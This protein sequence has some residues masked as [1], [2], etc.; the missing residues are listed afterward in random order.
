MRTRTG[1]TGTGTHTSTGT[2]ASRRR[3]TA[4][5]SSTRHRHRGAYRDGARRQNGIEAARLRAEVEEAPAWAE[6]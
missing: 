1:T 5:R 3:D 2:V 6:R 4:E